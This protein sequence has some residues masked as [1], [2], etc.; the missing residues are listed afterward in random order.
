M[1][2]VDIPTLPEIQALITARADASVSIYVSTTPH[3]QDVK[4]SRIAFGNLT[5]EALGQLDAV[6]FDKRRAAPIHHGA[7]HKICAQKTV[8]SWSSSL[9]SSVHCTHSAHG[10]GR[11]YTRSL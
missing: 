1:L 4:A 10:T 11:H 9:L 3:T 5:K 7:P 2:Y 6:G 8:F